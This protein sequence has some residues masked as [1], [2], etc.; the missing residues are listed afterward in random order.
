MVGT[1][2]GCPGPPYVSLTSTTGHY[3]STIGTRPPTYCSIAHG[4]QNTRSDDHPTPPSDSGA[5]W[6][7]YQR[8]VQLRI[9][10][11]DGAPAPPTF[12]VIY[13]VIPPPS[14]GTWLSTT[15]T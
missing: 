1:G 8:P 14:L 12:L 6:D 4:R 15:A 11:L 9:P 13:Y 2:N 10:L 7:Q 3:G 5:I